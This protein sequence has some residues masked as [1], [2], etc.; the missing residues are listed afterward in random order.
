MT[1]K[2]IKQGRVELDYED[3]ALI[4]HYTVETVRQDER[5]RDA[6]VVDSKLEFR[7]IKIKTLTENKNMA[8]IAA[9][10]VDK[11]KYIHPSRVE[12]IE[13]LLIKLRKHSLAA[14]AA[15]AT[16]N[17]NNST[18]TGGR[19]SNHEGYNDS[20]SH[21]SNENLSRNG[22]NTLSRSQSTAGREREKDRDRDRDNRQQIQQTPTLLEQLPPAYMNQLD[23]YLEMLYQVSGKSEKDKEEGLKV[24]ERGTS[25][26]LKLCRDVMNLEQL[27]QNSTVMGAL[28]RVLQEE[29]KKSMDLTFNI[30]RIFLAFSN[31]AEMHSL[32]AS[33]RIG[34]LTMKAVELEMKRAEV[35]EQEALERE[36][37]LNAQIARAKE[38]DPSNYTAAVD[39]VRR[40]REKDL[41]KQKAFQRKQDKLL[42]VGFY[43]LL[44]L[45]EDLSVERKMIKKGLITSLMA[46]LSHN[47]EDLLIL[48]VTFLKK[49]STIEENKNTMKESGMVEKLTRLIPC[50]SQPLITISLRFL[51]NL[52]FDKELRE[53]ML[54]CGFVPKLINLLKTP[55]FRAKTLKLLYHLSVDDRCK[56]MFTYTDGVPMLVGMAL[57]F[58]KDLLAKELGALLVNL[59]HNG[60]NVE[61]MIANKGLNLLMDRFSD[62]RDP[63]LLKVIRN[64]SLWT[65][66]QLQELESPELNYK[67]RGL[68]SP[69][70]KTLLEILLDTDSHD[71]LVEL[72]G[73]LANMTTYD[74]PAS[75]NW[76]KLLRDY[77]L[78]SLFCKLLVPGMAQND[79]LLE[80]VMLI[81]NIASDPQAASIF[82]S[83]TLIGMLYQLWKEKGDDVELLLQL[84]HCF[85]KLFMHQSSR[86]EAMYSTRIV[87]DIIE[88][89]AHRNFAAS[90]EPG[91][92]GQEI[93]RKRF[94][95][96]N[97]VWLS[98]MMQMEV[99][100]GMMPL[101]FGGSGY[102]EQDHG[103]MQAVHNPTNDADE[104]DDS[105]N[106]VN[107]ISNGAR[108]YNDQVFDAGDDIQW[109]LDAKVHDKLVYGGPISVRDP[110]QPPD[111]SATNSSAN[112]FSA[113]RISKRVPFRD[114]P[115]I[116]RGR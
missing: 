59:S 52:S 96:Y 27:I 18:A 71:L 99:S 15:A 14:A 38:G 22:G 85:H 66:N 60:R 55:T 65:F 43:I 116:F 106:N 73:C 28:T 29:Y 82:S 57:N 49:L 109:D 42:F 51:F 72:V 46:M 48:C 24:Q 37:E 101:G 2:R 8:Q 31:F 75:S 58:P 12:E 6:E 105:D 16:S 86:E 23:D 20:E 34:V 41:Q 69:H 17:T 44:N 9:D 10:I 54:K 4:V 115:D 39:K 83:S 61:L 5:G 79:L 94:E 81:A 56:S 74:L 45:A 11:C 33:F 35:R 89:L 112:L 113:Q 98:N 67:F 108:F 111:F 21:S 32:M 110:F 87:V 93:I 30:L 95:S 36:Q 102:N 100:N 84:I 68:W 70:V 26:I 25:M 104:L 62:K 50:S 1:S 92:L 63:I 103:T 13:Q 80:I 3:S 19:L 91:Q 47:F 77:G 114:R 97:K 107:N 90:G 88:C 53:Q 40:L 78:V 76:S 64:I 7:K